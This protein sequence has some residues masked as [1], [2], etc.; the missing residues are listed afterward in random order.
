[1]NHLSR[2][3]AVVALS[4]LPFLGLAQEPAV[5]VPLPATPGPGDL[6]TPVNPEPIPI[7]EALRGRLRPL[8][9]PARKVIL[10]I[11]D[12]LAA[13]G[14]TFAR[15]LSP[16]ESIEL[17]RFPVVGRVINKPPRGE[18]NDSAG[19]AS[20]LA[21]GYPGPITRVAVD[22]LGRPRR[23]ILE[24]AK[25]RGFKVGLVSDTRLTHATP[26]AF[27]SHVTDRENEP[28]IARHLMQSGFDLMLSGGLQYFL[29]AEEGGQ[30]PQGR[31]LLAEAARAGYTVV[32][33]R[34]DLAQAVSRNAERVLGLFAP[35]FLPYTYE[36]SF[37]QG[38]TLAEMTAAA[39]ATLDRHPQGFLLMVEAGKFDPCLHQYDAAEL[40]AQVRE[41]ELA[42][43]A[44]A[45]FVRTRSDAL[46]VV[47]P[48][49]GTSGLAIVE[50]FD[51]EKFRRLATSTRLLADRLAATSPDLAAQL[52]ATFPGLT[53]TAAD[54]AFLRG[55]T[56]KDFPHRL[57]WMV[58]RKLGLE[59]LP[60]LREFPKGNAYD[61]TGEDQFLHALG[62][63][64]GLFGGVM[65][66]WEIPRRLAA[67]MGFVFP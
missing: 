14:L 47:V 24:E 3:L 53:F 27:G 63:H 59:F 51:P 5:T 57:G 55:A 61:H 16:R 18:V 7:D 11:L 28:E 46:V 19:A 66:Q 10:V 38:P 12:G 26:A 35:S 15:A 41:S 4:L 56:A 21:T 2:L 32:K 49:H 43:R 52:A 54:L 17:D 25:A 36:P 65:R 64:Q 42:L 23:T 34:A 1:M 6:I 8:G 58:N 45:D 60:Y 40:A 33:T 48:D 30:Q 44:I 50:S 67:A 62:A 31:H 22:E 9:K 39:L 29:P 37:R 13:S 20:A